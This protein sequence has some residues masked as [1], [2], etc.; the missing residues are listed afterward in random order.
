MVVRG[1][2]TQRPDEQRR[3]ADEED[4][5]FPLLSDMDAALAAALRLPTFRARQ[6][7]RLKRAVPMV[8]RERAVRHVHFPVADTPAAVETSLDVAKGL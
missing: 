3:F 8:D 5:P 6:A 4:I 2:S 1:V 7:L